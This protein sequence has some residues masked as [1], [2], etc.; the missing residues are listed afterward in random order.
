MALK[1]DIEKRAFRMLR[2]AVVHQGKLWDI[3]LEL[4]KLRGL[5][6][7]QVVALIQEQSGSAD[8]GRD[9]TEDDFDDY[10]ALEPAPPGFNT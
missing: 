5:E 9:L 6:Q 1:S 8:T 4:A 3:A 2:A 10:L 7:D